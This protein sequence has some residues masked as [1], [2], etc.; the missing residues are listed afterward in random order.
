MC[1]SEI[2]ERFFARDESALDEIQRK[3]GGCLL[4][5]AK[6]IL[7]EDGS[8][9]ECVNTAYLRAW[10]AIP[11]EKPENLAAYLIKI[12]RRLA[13]DV[14]RGRNRGKR[15]A[16]EY[17]ASLSE[18]EACLSAGDTTSEL[19]DGRA[20]AAAINAYLREISSEARCLFVGRYYYADSLRTLAGYYGMSEAKVKSSLYRTRQGLKKYLSQEG[21]EI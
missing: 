8:C 1:D 2:I 4:W 21:F 16:S 19:V 3:Y 10:G 6:N 17:D 5:I 20:L 18:L 7:G 13:I 9:E 15:S 14:L 11:P 12:T